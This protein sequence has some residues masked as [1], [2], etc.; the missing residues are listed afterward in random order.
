[1]YITSK[2]QQL[3][4]KWSI[5]LSFLLTHRLSMARCA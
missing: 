2:Y 3:T 5:T 1:M 4:S